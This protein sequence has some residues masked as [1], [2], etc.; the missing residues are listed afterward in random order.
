MMKGMS[1]SPLQGVRTG[2]GGTVLSAAA[3]ALAFFYENQDD[4]QGKA[5][6]LVNLIMTDPT[7][8]A[9]QQVHGQGA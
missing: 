4:I 2:V 6:L 5:E 7:E 3:A 8:L 1:R 9:A